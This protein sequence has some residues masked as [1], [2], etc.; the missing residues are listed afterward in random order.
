MIRAQLLSE[1]FDVPVIQVKMINNE[2]QTYKITDANNNNALKK[3]PKKI[4]CD[5]D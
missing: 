1:K 4:N 3:R 2:K 5:K